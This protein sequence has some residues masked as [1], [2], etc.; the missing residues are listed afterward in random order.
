[1]KQT[2]WPS[3]CP[4]PDQERSL[5][6]LG[7]GAGG[8]LSRDLLDEVIL[9]AFQNPIL[10]KKEDQAQLMLP[11]T[12]CAFTTDSYVVHPIEFPGGDIGKLA[13]CGTINDLAVG[14]ARPYYL[15]TSFI[16]EEG[17]SVSSL[18]KVVT[19]MANTCHD[20]GVQIV[21]GDT[22]VVEKGK[23]DQIFINTS[24]I[25]CIHDEIKLGID[26]L[27]AGDHIIVSGT[28]ADHGTAILA[29]R[30]GFEF[31][32][33]LLS[34]CAPLDSLCQLILEEGKG[35]V[36]CMRDPTRGGLSS[37][38]FEIAADSRLSM[39]ISEQAIPVRREVRSFCELLG[40]DPLYIANEG[41]LVVFCAPEASA[42]LLKKMQD[43]P[44]GK[45]SQL[46]G[47]VSSMAPGKVLV[48]GLT[49]VKRLLPQIAGEQ[50]PR[51]C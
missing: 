18:Q 33:A 4:L 21:C 36:R 48:E 7:H 22:K 2:S 14:G 3:A 43:H 28:L 27:I 12:R 45:N 30:S 6:T 23:A 11:S 13:V 26:Q 38:L 25:G 8:Q 19:S 29:C 42:N 47:K 39:E 1:M 37:S 46:I 20:T 31:S 50:L 41:K 44:L 51:I 9:P 24:G 34:D 35:K 16:V 10:E 17:F 49:G 40:L 15:S 32:G 5:I